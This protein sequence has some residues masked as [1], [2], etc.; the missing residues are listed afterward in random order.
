MSVSAVPRREKSSTR[1]P[2]TRDRIAEAALAILDA[3]DDESALTMRT[4][5]EEL[6]VQAPSLYAHVSGIS[7]IL[8]LVHARINAG[9]DLASLDHP[10]P[11]VGLREFAHLYRSA[12]QSHQVAATIIITRS[13]NG[14]HALAV[15]EA[16]ATCL[17]RAGVPVANVM[18][19]MSFLDSLVLGSA[20]EPFAAGFTDKGGDYARDYPS[21]A[22]ALRSRR[23]KHIDDDGFTLGLDAFIDVVSAMSVDKPE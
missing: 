10:D 19:T 18:P 6:S 15:Y 14:D 7:D 20:I 4:L 22:V 9:I 5:A 3:A 2:V 21:L 8:D 1:E 13:F 16:V 11:L 23:R 17:R 12:Y